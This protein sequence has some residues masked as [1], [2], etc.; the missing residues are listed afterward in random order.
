[1]KQ[2]ENLVKRINVFV[3]LLGLLFDPEDGGYMP[4]R[5]VG[6]SSNSTVL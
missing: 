3:T 6:L 2:E 4:L 1:M 5:N